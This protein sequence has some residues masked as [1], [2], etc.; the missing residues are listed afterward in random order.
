MSFEY[1]LLD[2]NLWAA[3]APAQPTVVATMQSCT[4]IA[5][6]RAAIVLVTV[7]IVSPNAASANPNSYASAVQ[8]FDE[9]GQLPP[10][11][12]SSPRPPLNSSIVTLPFLFGSYSSEVRR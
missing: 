7:P 2:A 4:S 3:A 10:Q 6:P 8:P 9:N 12:I 5:S 11:H 1:V